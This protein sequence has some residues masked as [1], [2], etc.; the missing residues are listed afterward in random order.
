MAGQHLDPECEEGNIEYKLRL[1]EPTPQ[2]FHQLVRLLMAASLD[3]DVLSSTA[4][5]VGW[6]A[7][8]ECL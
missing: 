7:C 4:S 5:N 1:K 8:F 6:V 3:V 2:R